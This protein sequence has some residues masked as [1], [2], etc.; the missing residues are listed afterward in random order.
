MCDSFEKHHPRAVWKQPCAL[1]SRC[2]AQVLPCR[3]ARLTLAPSTPYIP[4]SLGSPEHLNVGS[5]SQACERHIIIPPLK[6]EEA[7]TQGD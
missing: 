6:D 2:E 1:F 5:F 7:E 4:L 3:A